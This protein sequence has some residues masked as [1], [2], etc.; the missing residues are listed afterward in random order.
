MSDTP[1]PETWSV[2]STEGR[3]L[4]TLETPEHLQVRQIGVDFIL[5]IWTDELDVS[6]VRVYTL[7]RR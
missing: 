1:G 3:L 2:F 7:E 4:G 5:G 6:Y